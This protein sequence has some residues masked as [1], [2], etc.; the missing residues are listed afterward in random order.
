MASHFA[1]GL[2]IIYF[3]VKL[4]VTDASSVCIKKLK[5]GNYWA[6]KSWMWHGSN[7]SSGGLVVPSHYCSSSYLSHPMQPEWSPSCQQHQFSSYHHLHLIYSSFILSDMPTV[8]LILLYA[9]SHCPATVVVH[10]CL[11]TTLPQLPLALAPW[12]YHWLTAVHAPK[13]SVTHQTHLLLASC[14]NLCSRNLFCILIR[15]RVYASA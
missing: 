14:V 5:N 10:W 11:A 7:P 12:S 9:C 13:L 8:Y 4:T 15:L 2:A 6:I 1:S 3:H